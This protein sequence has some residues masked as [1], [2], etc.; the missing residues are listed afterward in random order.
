MKALEFLSAL[1]VIVFGGLAPPAWA[2]VANVKVVTDA[3]PDYY[4]M[5][6]LIHSVASR[7]AGV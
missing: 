5:D 6:S 2:Q 4:D 7:W 1:A 3:S